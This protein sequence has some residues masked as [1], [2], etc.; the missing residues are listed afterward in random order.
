M[1]KASILKVLAFG[2]V[3]VMMLT[4]AVGCGGGTTSNP[5]DV[6]GEDDDFLAGGDFTYDAGSLNT[7][8]SSGPQN[9]QGGTG[10]QNYVSYDTSHVKMTDNTEIFKNI[11]AELKGKTVT[12]ADWGEANADR[13]QLVVKKFTADTGI[14]VKMALYNES[15]FI[16]EVANQINAGKSPD[17]AACNGTFP[18]ALG[19]VQE[20]P[21]IF[22]VYDGFWDERVS[23]ATALNGKMFFVCPRN[24]PF[25][26]GEL[27]YYNKK[28]FR[29]AGAKEPEEYYKEGNWTYET[30]EK[31]MDEL[32]DAGVCDQMGVINAY[33]IF[34]QSGRAL[35]SYDPKTGKY[36]G[37]AT[38]QAY[39]DA[40]KYTNNIF[41]VKHYTGAGVNFH[42][43]NRGTAAMCMI[44]TYG[45]KYNGYFKDMS[46]TDIAAVPAPTS[47][48]GNKLEYITTGYRG[49]GICKGAKNVDAAYYFLRYFL[50]I[51]KYEAA[52]AN[53][54]ANKVLEKYFRETQLPLFQNSKV[55][56]YLHT[57]P[58]N[59]VKS[60]W[61]EVSDVLGKCQP[62]QVL[63]ELERLVPVVDSAVAQGNKEMATYAAQFS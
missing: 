62:E 33:T 36:V 17:I 22:N 50:D 45:T 21:K 53:I 9:S 16:Q 31:C 23:E 28:M 42:A 59:L 32:H 2:L 63:V 48:N 3:L 56:F 12:F 49:Y 11:P 57:G 61:D 30:M 40:L 24:N 39:V 7:S 34:A 37:N 20:L 54:F 1:K 4:L 43:F 8:N 15:T 41:N 19:V 5:S 60:S 27:V 51:D 46:P 58:L 10:S 6:S 29:Q 13:Y 38:D 18:Q 47:L 35:I 44:G 55:N 26:G 25:A 52:G 14:K